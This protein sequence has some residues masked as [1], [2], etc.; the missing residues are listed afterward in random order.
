MDDF[1]YLIYLRFKWFG[2]T[3]RTFGEAPSDFHTW[4]GPVDQ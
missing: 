2:M 1:N 3:S 4:T